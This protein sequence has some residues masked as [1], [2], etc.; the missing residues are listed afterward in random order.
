MI[1]VVHVGTTDEGG[2]Y[3]AMVLISRCLELQG[4][5]SSIL[6]RNKK[7]ENNVGR[8]MCNGYKRLNSKIKNLFNL[9]LS[10]DNIQ[11]D[12][13]GESI[14]NESEVKNADV[15]FLHWTN[16]FLSYNAIRELK[17]LNKKV[18]FVMHDMWLMTGGCHYDNYC[19]GYENGCVTCPYAH[20]KVQRYIANNSFVRKIKM[21]DYINPVIISPS[22]WLAKMAE[23]SKITASYDKHVINNPVDTA[24]FRPYSDDETIEIKKKYGVATSDKLVVFSAFNAT[25]NKKK[26][27]SY[28]EKALEGI[29]EDN[30]TLL[31]CGDKEENNIT[32]IDKV[33]VKYAGFIRERNSL[34]K[35]F[36][37]AD[38]VVAPSKQENYS[39]V[40]L[41]ALSCGTPVVAFNVGGMPEIIDHKKTGY[42]AEYRNV[43][44]LCEGIRY[45]IVNKKAMSENARE[46]RLRKNTLETVGKT[47]TDLIERLLL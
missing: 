31:I 19:A 23:C 43:E 27:F 35:I 6:L 5:E 45:C 24:I 34:A 42:I 10:F 30:L 1:K 3:G 36:S 17:K 26:G 33:K 7:D 44:Q 11:A 40:V 38:V 47:Y 32:I 8:G 46:V 21:L 14:V 12:Y 37:A 28:L 20:N 13:W 4:V 2:A 15:I 41:E 39:G 16:S 9:F 25:R 22:D 18:V 29:V